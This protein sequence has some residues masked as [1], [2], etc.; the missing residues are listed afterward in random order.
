MTDFVFRETGAFRF[1]LHMKAGNEHA[2]AVYRREGFTEEGVLRQSHINPAGARADA[3]I[4]SKLRPEWSCP[5]ASAS[6]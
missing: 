6:T 3:H 1:W 5:T 2:H 4:F